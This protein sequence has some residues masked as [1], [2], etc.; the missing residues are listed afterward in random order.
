MVNCASDY[1]TADELDSAVRQV[2]LDWCMVVVPFT[3]FYIALRLPDSQDSRKRDDEDSKDENAKDK[4]S[5][6]TW[7]ELL[8]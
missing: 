1:V 6:P 2:F 3:L 5:N 8:D 4:D 7:L